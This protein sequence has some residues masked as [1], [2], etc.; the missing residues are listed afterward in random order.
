MTPNL[1]FSLSHEIDTTFYLNY[2]T[3]VYIY[4]FNR[5]TIYITDI[6]KFFF[7]IFL[8]DTAIHYPLSDNVI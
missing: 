8:N 7:C 1:L 2:T 6:D 3:S 5:F 4:L